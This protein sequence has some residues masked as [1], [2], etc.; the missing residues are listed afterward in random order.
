MLVAAEEMIE[1]V[2]VEAR[3]VEP[4]GIVAIESQ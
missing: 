2:V 4:F 3:P 1:V